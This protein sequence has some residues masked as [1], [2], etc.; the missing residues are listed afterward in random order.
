M[1]NLRGGLAGDRPMDLV[2]DR[3]EK[4]DADFPR[5]V[6]INA[7]GIDAGDFL[8][9]PPLGSAD[10][11]NPPREFLE[12]VEAI[13]VRDRFCAHRWF[14]EVGLGGGGRFCGESAGRSG[15]SRLA[16]GLAVSPGR[17]L[18]G[19]SLMASSGCSISNAMLSTRVPIVST[20][21][22]CGLPTGRQALLFWA[23][24]SRWCL[25]SV[26]VDYCNWQS[27]RK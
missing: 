11:L 21:G 13:G 6:I 5:G 3:L 14:F 9:E 17:S 15:C 16:Y 20:R 1:N 7:G 2:W 4:A 23:G 27:R 22:F 26:I 25:L 8:V 19:E 24:P 12:V 18:A 10:V